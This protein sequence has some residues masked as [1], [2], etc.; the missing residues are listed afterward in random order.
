MSGPVKTGPV[1]TGAALTGAV[2]T[3]RIDLGPRSYPIVIG[4]DLLS[5]AG[6]RIAEALPGRRLAVVTDETVARLHLPA[7]EASLAAAGIEHFALT[8]PPGETSKSFAVF[9]DLCER[10]LAARIERGTVI[11]ALGGG[12]VGDLAGF[13]AAVVLR[14]LD[15]VQLPTTLLAQVDS[16]VGGKTAIDTAAGKNLVG[17]FHQPR[18]VLADIAA[19]ETLPPRELKA[20]YAE[21]VKYGLIDDPDFFAWCEANGGALLAGDRALRL[22]AVA[23][24]C[25]AK[26]A[27]VA[28]DEREAGERAL[29][30]LGHTFAHALE[31]AAGFGDALLHGEAV[32]IGMVMAFDLSVALGLCPASDAAR[33]RGHFLAAGLPVGLDG[34]NFGGPP[35]S[36]EALLGFMA[37]DKKVAAGRVRFVLARGIGKAFVADDVDPAAVRAILARAA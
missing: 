18:L 31:S 29:L 15:Y 37:S 26:A 24:A 2:E 28:R 32:A 7:L 27:I 20:G 4:A 34:L 22:H 36:A 16:S 12:V 33:I 35:P 23:H 10:L 3:V 21:T 6:A 13:A 1:K 5:G 9:E 19:L 25:R 14:G 8:V 30:N 17:A 11:A